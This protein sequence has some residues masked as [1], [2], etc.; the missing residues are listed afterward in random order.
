VQIPT[1]RRGGGWAANDDSDSDSDDE[2]I[3]MRSRAKAASMRRVTDGSSAGQRTPVSARAGTSDDDSEAG[4]GAKIGVGVSSASPASAKKSSRAQEAS[5]R[6]GFDLDVTLNNINRWVDDDAVAVAPAATAEHDAAVVGP[7]APVRSSEPQPSIRGSRPGRSPK[8]ARDANLSFAKARPEPA[9]PFAPTTAPAAAA[10]SSS[11]PRP[12]TDVVEEAPRDRRERRS[13]RTPATAAAEPAPPAA[14]RSS[15]RR[16]DG[17]SSGRRRRSTDKKNAA[18]AAA[19]VEAVP[20]EAAPAAPA[21]KPRA[22]AG[23]PAAPPAPAAATHDERRTNTPVTPETAQR[24]SEQPAVPRPPAT[25]GAAN[26]MTDAMLVELLRQPPKHVKQ[27]RT[28]DAYRKFFSGMSRARIARL[29]ETAYDAL[30]PAD[31]AAKVAKRL[32]L[33]VDVLGD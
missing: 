13:E 24:A 2:M 21:E 25:P 18:A 32:S 4:L 8:A 33:V 23:N 12:D 16:G 29:L 17:E 14:A 30:E 11:K 22:P 31:A 26:A 20:A 19:P 9:E 28:R 5:R 27:L 6:L 1:R 15:R 3:N 7:P 10:G